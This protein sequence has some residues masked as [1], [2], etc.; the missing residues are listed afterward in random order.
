VNVEIG[1]VRTDLSSFD[2]NLAGLTAFR[3]HRLVSDETA[4]YRARK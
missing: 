2:M 3:R 4:T 1:A